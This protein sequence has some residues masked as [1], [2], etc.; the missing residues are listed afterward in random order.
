VFQ[1]ETCAGV[2]SAAQQEQN[3]TEV[4]LMGKEKLYRE[5]WIRLGIKVGL[6][7]SHF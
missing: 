4:E 5:W 7:S 3:N 1:S 2:W 6:E